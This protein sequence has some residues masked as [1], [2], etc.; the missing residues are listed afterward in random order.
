MA[1]NVIGSN[2]ACQ[3]DFSNIL[4]RRANGQIHVAATLGGR[5]AFDLDHTPLR[6]GDNAALSVLTCQQVVVVGLD[7]A[8]AH[9]IAQFNRAVRRCG[10]EFFF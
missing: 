2:Q 10:I 4:N 5:F 9:G 3:L 8:L 1:N 7:P 6:I